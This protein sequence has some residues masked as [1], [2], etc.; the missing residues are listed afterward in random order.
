MVER[1]VDVVGG[2]FSGMA[3]AWYLR[4]AGAKVRL[5][6]KDSRL[7]G[8]LCTEH[9]PF[10][11][12]EK[13]ANGILACEEVER[14]F[15]E[16]GLTPVPTFKKFPRRYVYRN[17]R[18]TALPLKGLEWL[19]V[20]K[21]V[22]EKLGGFRGLKPK[23]GESLGQWSLRHWGEG[24][25]KCLV[26]PA[27]RGVFAAQAE[28]L[29][30]S[31]VLRGFMQPLPRGEKYRGTLAPLGGMG[32]LIDAW[33]VALLRAG[34][35]IELNTEWRC[36]GKA[37]KV[38]LC[39][40]P[41]K[42]AHYMSYA[43]DLDSLKR[44][45]RVGLVSV[46]VFFKPHT[47]DLRGFGILS[48]VHGG[49]KAMGILFNSDIFWERKEQYRSETFIFDGSWAVKSDEEILAGA[50]EDRAL[51]HS[52][53]SEVVAHVVTRQKNALPLY[54]LELEEFLM[55]SSLSRGRF[56]LFGNSYGDLGLARILTAAQSRTAHW[57][58][59]DR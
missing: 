39:L 36:D 20:I 11:V 21:I 18:P 3:A 23:P 10:G 8:L 9:T 47:K 37:S 44:L 32:E 15:H 38:I 6:E 52:D 53:T 19:K 46:T 56:E 34:V 48:P 29:S 31:L 17:G 40:S 57:L 13:A 51:I 22:R 35:E 50:L 54:G 59:G 16:V 25:T 14:L 2:G 43:E 49:L 5:F 24:I 41:E 27:F 7:G 28:D 42:A 4:K 55:S 26:E 45:P 33:T 1:R 12:V 30:A 58:G